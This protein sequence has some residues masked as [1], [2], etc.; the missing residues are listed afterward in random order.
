MGSCRRALWVVGFI[1]IRWVHSGE[2]LADVG[3]I[4]RAHWWSS[5]M[6]CFVVFIQSCIAVVGL[7]RVRWVISDAPGK[8]V[9]LFGLDLGVVGF[10]KV[11]WVHLNAIWGF[12][13][14]RPGSHSV[15]SGALR[16]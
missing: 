6:F 4:R 5:D 9:G 12:I 1:L 10:M 2:A 14:E 11:R 13:G 7:I 16:G 3:F 8:S 15:H